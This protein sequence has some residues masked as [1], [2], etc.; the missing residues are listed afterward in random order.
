VLASNLPRSRLT[1]LLFAAP[2]TLPDVVG[3]APLPA[4]A[5]LRDGTLTLDHV[6]PERGFKGSEL[7]LTCKQCNNTAGGTIEAHMQGLD[8]L[9]APTRRVCHTTPST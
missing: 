3:V 2:G 4:E 7:V 9:S 1:R 8:A 6:P 5:V